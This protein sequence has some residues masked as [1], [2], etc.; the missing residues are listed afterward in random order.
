MTYV[1]LVVVLGIFAVMSNVVI[2]N[3]GGFQAKVDIKN[4]SKHIT[5]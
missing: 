5:L 3:Y 2:F 4:L 1:E